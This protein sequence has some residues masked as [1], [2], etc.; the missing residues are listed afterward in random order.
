MY[1]SVNL[2]SGKL[3]KSGFQFTEHLLYSS[4]TYDS[5]VRELEIELEKV[6]A[7]MDDIYPVKAT[8]IDDM[9]HGSGTSSPTENH[10]IRRADNIQ[11]KCL[12]NRIDEMKRHQQ[13]IN[14]AMVYMTETE[15]LFIKLKYEREKSSREC[16]KEMHIE[17]TRWYELRQEIVHKVAKYLGI[18]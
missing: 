7:S 12:K 15:R 17:K 4:K 6:I 11:V 10:A 14:Q 3:S 2:Y 8:V 18:Y 1:L 5:A 13:A 16:W 9:P